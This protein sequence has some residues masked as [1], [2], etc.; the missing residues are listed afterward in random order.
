MN[1][2]NKLTLIKSIHTLIWIFL[3]YCDFLYAVCRDRQ[4]NQFLALDGLW[5]RIAR[6][7]KRYS[8]LN[9]TVH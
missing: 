7:A 8:P 9:L 4:Q 1:S 6:R 3:Q 5:L 2:K